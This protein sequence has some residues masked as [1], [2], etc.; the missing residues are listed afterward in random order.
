[1]GGRVWF[2]IGQ[3][4]LTEVYYPTID[5]PQ[6]RD[7]EFLFSDGNGLFL[8]EKRDLD[9]QI[10]RILPSQGYRI[11]RHDSEGRFSFVKEIIA[12]PTRP[13][14]LIHTKLEGK[15]DFLKKLKT[16][17]L[18]APHLEVGGEGNNAYVVEVSGQQLLVLRS[19]PLDRG[20]R[21]VRFLEA[22]L[23]LCRTQRRL[24]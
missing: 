18:C 13:C 23:W 11:S 12:E 8:E 10:E 3:G 20:W 22:F 24:H 14:V 2:T 1:M 6:M 9:Y 7:L 16:Y 21:I 19:R 4:I 5:R 17:V 15:R